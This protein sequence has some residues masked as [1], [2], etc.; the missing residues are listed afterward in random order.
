MGRLLRAVQ[1]LFG[2]RVCVSIYSAQLVADCKVRDG[3]V[4]MKPSDNVFQAAVSKLLTEIFD[5]P[6]GGEAYI[7]NPGDVGLHRQLE[8]IPAETAS[9]QPFPGRPSIAAHV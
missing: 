8:A 9:K 5:G 1:M 3:E 7:L 6:P 4:L 2:D